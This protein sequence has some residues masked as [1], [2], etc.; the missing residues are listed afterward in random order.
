[1]GSWVIIELSI[2]VSDRAQGYPSIWN[3]LQFLA[4]MNP[5]Y[6]NG[7]NIDH[8]TYSLLKILIHRKDKQLAKDIKERSAE[9][10][11]L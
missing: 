2:L 5:F 10:D 9:V 11:M 1:M 8:S 4:S 3:I 6:M 7:V